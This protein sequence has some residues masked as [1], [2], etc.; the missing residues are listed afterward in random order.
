MTSTGRYGTRTFFANKFTWSGLPGW[1]LKCSPP[2]F[3]A[4]GK[5]LCGGCAKWTKKRRCCWNKG[6]HL[7]RGWLWGEEDVG[8]KN[9]RSTT[10]PT[11]CSHKQL[12]E[13]RT[14]QNISFSGTTVLAMTQ[15]KERSSLLSSSAQNT[16]VGPGSALQMGINGL[17]SFTPKI[18]L[19]TFPTL[20]A[21]LLI[22][23]HL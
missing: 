15:S 19:S 1:M 17:F 7:L 5:K 21:H 6:C 20:S 4:R 22:T 12:Q 18:F 2:A 8:Q 23:C 13:E 14:A 9:L 3:S 16:W 10:A 11:K